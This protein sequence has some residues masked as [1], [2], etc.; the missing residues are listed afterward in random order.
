MLAADRYKL[1]SGVSAWLGL[2]ASNA[3]SL[4]LVTVF[5]GYLLL[6]FFFS[7]KLF[8]LILSIEVR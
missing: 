2:L 8:S 6:L 5:S 4:A 1:C 7:T 3:M